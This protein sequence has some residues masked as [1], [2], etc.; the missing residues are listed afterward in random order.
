ML[1]AGRGGRSRLLYVAVIP[2]LPGIQAG[3]VMSR[4]SA[5]A[6]ERQKI[7]ETRISHAASAHPEDEIAIFLNSLLEDTRAVA[8]ILREM[9]KPRRAA[10]EAELLENASAAEAA[11]CVT[12][13]REVEARGAE[14]SSATGLLYR[15][16]AAERNFYRQLAVVIEAE[17]V[18]QRRIR[19]ALP[20]MASPRLEARL[21]HVV[22][23]NERTIERLLTLS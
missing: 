16:V 6:A 8:R 21:A 15:V 11:S 1:H 23:A 2:P 10:S 19:D 7:R 3:G 22:N 18:T 14:A 20:R 5:S 9:A 13:W 17:R 4:V 12:L